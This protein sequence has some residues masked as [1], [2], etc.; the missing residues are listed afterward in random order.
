VSSGACG[1]ISPPDFLVETGDG[2]FYLE[3]RVASAADDLITADRRRNRVYDS[4]NRLDS[5]NFFL[6][7]DVE[8]EGTADPATRG[9]RGALEEWLATLDPDDIHRQ[10]V[11]TEDIRSIA[12][13]EWKADDWYLVFRPWPK[14]PESR[15]GEQIRPLGVFGPSQASLVDDVKPLKK[16]LSDKGSAYGELD[17]P[18]VIAVR[19]SSMTTDEFDILGALYGSLQVQFIRGPDGQTATREVRAPDG[20]W[21]GGTHWRHRHVSGVLIARSLQLWTVSGDVPTLWEHPD[22]E[23]PSVV[24]PMWA[25]AFVGES[26]LEHVDPTIAPNELFGRSG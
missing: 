11:E 4:L 16:A 10:L 19:T 2:E 5:P 8:G 6:W 20:Y 24:P 13:F 14:A 23:R 18:F 7:V 22:P 17:R 1:N 25:R 12:P 3:A 26:S 21:F 15:G 9:L